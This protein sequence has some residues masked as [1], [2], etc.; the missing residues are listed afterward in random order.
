MVSSRDKIMVD[1]TTLR[2]YSKDL[3]GTLVS[4][5][6]SATSPLERAPPA[7][8]CDWTTGL[9]A[10]ALKGVDMHRPGARQAAVLLSRGRRPRTIKGY[11]SKF[12]RF[13]YFCEDEQ[14]LAGYESLCPMP[15]EPTTVLL[16][17]GYLQQEDKVHASSLQPYMSAIN[18]AHIDFGF[19]APAMGHDIKLARRGFGEVEGDNT[20]K[21][22]IRSPLPA[23]VAYEILQLGLRTPDL[24]TLRRCACLVT[25]YAWFARADTGILMRKAHVTRQPAGMGL[26]ERTKTIARH[27]AAP[28]WRAQDWHHDPAAVFDKLLGRWEDSRSHVDDDFYWSLPN[29]TYSD[30]QWNSSLIGHWLSEILDIL[31][32]Q[33][34][35][36]VAWSGHSLRSGGASAAYSIGV[37]ALI[38]MRFGIW[39]T[40]ASAQIYIDVLTLPDAA[41]YL[42][43]GHLLRGRLQSGPESVACGF[44]RA[45]GTVG[46]GRACTWIATGA[47]PS[48]QITLTRCLT[49]VVVVRD[50]LT[51]CDLGSDITAPSPSESNL[52][53]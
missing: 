31:K 9:A 41:A 3:D 2:P 15:A 53:T 11:E 46:I 8:K 27:I 32:I 26:N 16:F 34:P 49:S 51:L 42:F 5:D 20:L 23:L 50:D 28:I 35:A 44:W 6:T 47:T 48:V 19:S 52:D 37:D 7:T 13:C 14:I 18:Q 21:T 43:F 4:E 38:V 25:S 40:L 45:P 1:H 30:R 22:A 33:P 24:H 12:E 17:L 29:D 10:R 39:K 36:G